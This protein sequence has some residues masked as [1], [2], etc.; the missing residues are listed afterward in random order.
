VFFSI[1]IKDLL[2]KFRMAGFTVLAQGESTLIIGLMAPMFKDRSQNP[3]P[4][5]VWLPYDYTI[6]QIL[7]WLT[8]IM[9]SLCAI[10]IANLSIVMDVITYGIMLITGCLI[11]L[12]DY[13][14]INLGKNMKFPDTEAFIPL[15]KVHQEKQLMTL[16]I[17]NHVFVYELVWTSNIIG[18]CKTKKN[19]I[20]INFPICYKK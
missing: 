13:R 18:T 17:Q 6:S 20:F 8:Y 4:A 2:I 11:D 5:Q 12:L 9:N 1:L 14:L 16:I 15:S 7:Y 3:L 19:Q 10:S